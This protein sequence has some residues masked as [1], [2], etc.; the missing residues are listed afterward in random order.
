VVNVKKKDDNDDDDERK[1]ETKRNIFFSRLAVSIGG[2]GGA[3][4]NCEFRGS[5]KLFL[6]Q[7]SSHREQTDLS[8]TACAFRTTRR[9]SY[10]L[11]KEWK[12]GLDFFLLA[13]SIACF[14]HWRQRKKKALADRH[15]V[16]SLELQAVA[17][18]SAV[19][20]ACSGC[21]N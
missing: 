18:C 13:P 17:A 20:S 6:F 12:R 14:R 5:G 3:P 7:F 16:L 21:R 15:D 4:L 19:H 9:R 8:L 2:D 10:A 11:K 1:K